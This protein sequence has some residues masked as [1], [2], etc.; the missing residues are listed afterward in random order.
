MTGD[1]DGS[2]RP[3]S[4]GIRVVVVGLGI[5]GLSAAIECHRKGHSVIALEK[6]PKVSPVGGDCIS[7][8]ANGARVIR[9][10]ANGRVHDDLQELRCEG[11]D[12]HVFDAT[13]KFLMVYPLSGY[14]R[15]SGYTLN[16]GALVW[17]MYRHACE[18][19]IDIR[20]GCSVSE[21]WETDQGAGV[22]TDGDQIEGDCVILADGV[23]SRGIGALGL[24]LE[25]RET[26]LSAFRCYLSA[27][28]VA[29]DPEAR[30]VLEG[31]DSKDQLREWTKDDVYIAIWTLRRGKDILIYC[32]HKDTETSLDSWHGSVQDPTQVLAF[33][34]GWPVRNRL[35]AV[36]RHVPPGAF[37]DQKL[38]IRK[39]LKTW[40]SPSSKIMLIG[41]AAHAMIPITGQGGSQAIEDAAT[42]AIALELAGK[43]KV[44]QGL[45]VAERIRY[46]NVQ[47]QGF[48]RRLADR[49]A[50]PRYPRASLVQTELSRDFDP[51]FQGRQDLEA[52]QQVQG[53]QSPPDLS[54]IFDHDCQKY[55]Y[56]E[57]TRVMEAIEGGLPYI[58]RNIP[59]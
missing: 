24:T 45:A 23:H 47:V 38:V 35:D 25:S 17:R 33:L 56:Q 15:G 37:I 11:N 13:G 2:A 59:E 53:D 40:L 6:S 36:I 19:G 44:S 34:K 52:T 41:D 50:I 57:F 48:R 28:T 39:P 42:L 54:W 51:E 20:L 29:D 55:A 7:V 43:S 3:H 9:R 31:T 18:L 46:C 4:S 10:W 30:W 27:E 49:F 8:G 1:A 26:G 14:E 12:L 22:V 21:Y 16:R 58:P 5:A 32:Q